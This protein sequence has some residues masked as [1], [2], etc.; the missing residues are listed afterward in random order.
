MTAKKSGCRK[1]K[2]L[3]FHVVYAFFCGQD[4]PL[5]SLPVLSGLAGS[6]ENGTIPDA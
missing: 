5:A 2:F 6:P 3:F 1:L 4:A